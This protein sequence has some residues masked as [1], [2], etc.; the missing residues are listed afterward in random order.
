MLVNPENMSFND[1][2]FYMIIYG[3]PGTGKSTLALSAPDPILIDFDDGIARVK[4]YHRKTTL[5]STKYEDVLEDMNSPIVN[6]AKTIIIDTGGSFITYLQDWAMRTNPAVNITKGG[7]ISLKGFGA[8]KQ[9]FIR[10]SNYIKDTLHKNIIY[11]FHSQEQTDKDGLTQVRILCE[12]SAKNL[13]WQP[14]DFGGYMQMIGDKRTITFTPAQEFFAKGC[15]G[16]SGTYVIPECGP[17]DKNDFVTRLFEKARANI[18]KEDEIFAPQRAAYSAVM[19][20]I[21]PLIEGIDSVEKAQAV[22]DLIPTLNHALT[23]LAETRAIF[24]EKISSLGISWNR[25]KKCYESIKAAEEPT[26]EAPAEE[27]VKEEPAK[28]EPKAEPEVKKA[29]PV[30][31]TAPKKTVQKKA[32]AKKAEPKEK[33]VEA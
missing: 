2:T 10:F 25:T 28:E 33:K 23:S 20:E 32:P 14:C 21:T 18:A 19:A 3:T 5:I 12:G 15:F 27:P 31:K 4:A 7:S 1:K 17:S 11:V 13:V 29:E 8:V 6:N 16:I 26:P 22:S 9:E 24:A 30:K